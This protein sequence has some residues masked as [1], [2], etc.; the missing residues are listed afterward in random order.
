MRKLVLMSLCVGLVGLLGCEKKPVDKK[1]FLGKAKC[2]TDKDCA[3]GFICKDKACNEGKRTPE[4]LAAQ[5]KAELEARKA[6]EAKRTAT[7]PGEG[8]LVVRICPGFKNTPEAIGTVVATHT[9][10]KK[11]HYIDLALA[12]PDGGW[13]TEFT[14]YSLPLGKYEV[15]AT[16][17]IQVRGQPDGVHRLKCHE[18]V[19]KDA[20][21]DE[22]LRLMEVVLPE[23]EP[24]PE[25]NKA[26]KPKKKDCDWIAE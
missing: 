6:E 25:L 3:E 4:E 14:Y 10:T 17:G 24:K 1:K 20:C 11:K 23:D 21:K 2:E 19:K 7:K 15:Y 26:G 16:Y 12:I 13:D 9:E 22:T 8:K 5:K 18:E